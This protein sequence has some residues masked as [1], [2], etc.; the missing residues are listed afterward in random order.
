MAL[1]SEKLK[2]LESDLSDLMEW[3]RLGLVPK[4][5][6]KKHDAEIEATRAKIEEEE[7]KIRLMKESGEAEEYVTPRRTPPRTQ[8]TDSPTLPEMDI[9]DE[10]TALTDATAGE[11]LSDQS[12]SEEVTEVEAT[13]SYSEEDDPFSDKNRWKRGVLRN[14]EDEW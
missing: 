2:K 14:D 9:G 6:E 12:A 7:E 1:R 5:D 11:T 13:E 4:K 10:P 8:Y 3:K